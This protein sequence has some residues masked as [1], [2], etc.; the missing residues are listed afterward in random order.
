MSH[1]K[2]VTQNP[3]DGNFALSDIDTNQYDWKYFV[4]N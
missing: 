3:P 1:E 2:L 4:P